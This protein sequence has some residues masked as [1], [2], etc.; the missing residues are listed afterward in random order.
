MILVG[1]L[2]C[3]NLGGNIVWACATR[4]EKWV[5]GGNVYHAE[6]KRRTTPKPENVNPHHHQRCCTD[7][8]DILSLGELAGEFFVTFGHGFSLMRP[9]KADGISFYNGD[10]ANIIILRS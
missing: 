6:C 9:N 5:Q 1:E 3:V 7:E 8:E 4:H 10:K 2:V